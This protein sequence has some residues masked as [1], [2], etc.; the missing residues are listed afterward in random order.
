M[1]RLIIIALLGTI[2]LEVATGMALAAEVDANH[3]SIVCQKSAGG[4]VLQRDNDAGTAT[5]CPEAFIPVDTRRKGMLCGTVP[6]C[7]VLRELC[8]AAKWVYKDVYDQEE[9]WA[10]GV[11]Y[12]PSSTIDLGCSGERVCAALKDFCLIIGGRYSEDMTGGTVTGSCTTDPV[13]G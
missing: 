7:E 8:L 3:D 13:P 5:G 10:G 12:E 1:K 2:A 11:C 4:R 6:K 9:K